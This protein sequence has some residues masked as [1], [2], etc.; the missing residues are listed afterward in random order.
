MMDQGEF[1]KRKTAQ[2]KA[3]FAMSKVRMIKIIDLIEFLLERDPSELVV[4]PDCFVRSLYQK[5]IENFDL[6]SRD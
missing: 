4:L 6:E 1:E 3:I 2:I 5:S